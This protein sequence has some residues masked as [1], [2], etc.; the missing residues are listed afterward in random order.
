MATIVS[1]LD[2]GAASRAQTTSAS[3][4]TSLGDGDLGRHVRPAVVV[5]I[6]AVVD[7][8]LPCGQRRRGLKLEYVGQPG[9]GKRPAHR[10]RRVQ[11]VD[12]DE[13]LRRQE[14]KRDVVEGV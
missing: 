10:H 4:L 7:V 14:V 2:W 8:E 12:V 13:P 5:V 3:N 11:I 6:E 1:P 9:I